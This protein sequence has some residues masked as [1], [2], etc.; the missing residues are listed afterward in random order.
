MRGGL[1]EVNGLVHPW[2]L[3]GLFGE[4]MFGWF[5]LLGF[6]MPFA[7]LSLIWIGIETASCLDFSTKYGTG[8][9]LLCK[10]IRVTTRVLFLLG[11]RRFC[12]SCI[13]SL[14]LLLLLGRT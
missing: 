13:A 11:G 7:F 8:N 1:T 6:L 14:L 10:S 12:Y 9:L 4:L 3:S 2:L 5:L